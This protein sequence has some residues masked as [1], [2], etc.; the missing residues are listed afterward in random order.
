M[1][2]IKFSDHQNE[3][4]E[5]IKVGAFLTVKNEDKLNTMT[6]G[7][8]NVGVV[9]GLPI[10]TVLVRH[11]RY[12]HK[13]IEN[14]DQFTVS[15]PFAKKMKRETDY[16]GTKS[17]RDVNKFKELDLDLIDGIKLDT[18]FIKGNDVHYECEIVYKQD[19][20]PELLINDEIKEKYYPE[21]DYH[22]IY[23]GKIL[24]AYKE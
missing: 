19:M 21:G 4:M 9:W 3:V 15:V 6:I 11:S 22:T 18:P 10:F 5:G 16:C 12:T 1:E 13:L 20:K 2:K 24:G 7:W 23:Y 14:T 17:G 8:G